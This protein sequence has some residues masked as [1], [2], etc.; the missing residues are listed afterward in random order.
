MA[1]A[2]LFV[3]VFPR[4]FRSAMRPED[5]AARSSWF[6]PFKSATSFKVLHVMSYHSPWKWTDD[7][8]LGFQ[9]ATKDLDLDWRVM[10]MDTKRRSEEAYR[11]RIAGRIK[12]VIDR[13]KPDLVFTGDDDAQ[14]YVT[15]DYVNSEIPFVFCAVNADPADYGLVGS[16]NVTGVREEMHYIAAVSLLKKL[17][18]SVRRIV[19]VSDN[20]PMWPPMI[21]RMKETIAS[22]TEI[23]IV[24]YDI[25]DTFEQFKAAVLEYQGR[26]DAI[27]FFGVFEF[28]GPEGKNVPME[29]V[30]RWFQ[31]HNKLPDFSFWQDRVDKGT[32]CA[33]TVSGYAQGYQA[34][35]LA[36]EILVGQQSPADLP[37]RATEKG[38]PVINL[39]AARRLGIRP[40]ADTLLT[41]SVV[42]QSGL[43]P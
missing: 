1:S 35:L 28:L 17:A 15:A 20:G 12:E 24:G 22:C 27:G 26:V 3:A 11:K 2:L 39:E 16:S 31:A 23:E 18:P 8:I 29:E 38:I 25:F 30:L 9:A 43:T 19:M 13:W 37:M 6:R 40:D 21:E 34:G 41:A 14:R 10:Q 42:R 5:A 4:E 33:V 36:R 7:Q 32:L